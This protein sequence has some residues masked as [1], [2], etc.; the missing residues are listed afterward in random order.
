[1]NQKAPTAPNHTDAGNGSKA[2]CRGSNTSLAVASSGTFAQLISPRVM[3]MQIECSTN[4]KTRPGRITFSLQ[5]GSV[6]ADFDLDYF[7]IASLGGIS[8]DEF[9]AYRVRGL[10]S[11]MSALDSKLLLESV[12]CHQLD[13]T[14]IDQLLRRYFRENLAVLQQDALL[15]HDLL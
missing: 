10:T 1:M 4:S 8:F 15:R 3:Q 13:S 12:A 14:L 5:G 2:I 6:F 9:G 7:G 11:R